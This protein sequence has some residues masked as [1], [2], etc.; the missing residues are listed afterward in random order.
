MLGSPSG[1]KR[2]WLLLAAALLAIACLLGRR[3]LRSGPD[4]AG[5]V[6]RDAEQAQPG[7]RERTLAERDDRRTER[8][9]RLDARRSLG[10][11][12]PAAG[13]RSRTDGEAGRARTGERE[14]RERQGTAGADP[15]PVEAGARRFSS[16]ALVA[17][18]ES[19][20]PDMVSVV[21]DSATWSEASTRADYLN[22][23]E[24]HD[25]AVAD[26]VKAL[27]DEAKA[28]VKR[29]AAVRREIKA[30]RD[31]IAVKEKEAAAARA[32]AEER[33]GELKAAQAE[34]RETL[35]G[36]ESRSQALSD[37]LANI[38]EQIASAGARAARRRPRSADP[39]ADGR[40]HLRK[41]GERPRRRPACDRGGDRSR[42]L[43]RHHPLHL[44]RWPRLLLLTRL[45]LLGRGQL[46]AQRRRL[47]LQPAR[48][49]R[50]R[51]L[52][53]TGSR[54][55]D[56]RLRQRRPRLDDDRRTRLRHG[57]R[58]RP[59]LALLAG[60]LDRRVH[61][62]PPVRLLSSRG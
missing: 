20:T 24:D 61:R 18:Y 36:L 8:G 3:R 55:V 26:R 37:N 60:R 1:H 14:A 17:I 35:D 46:C 62:P 52:G 22:Q 29:M 59:A 16:S 58:A 47:P 28:A 9:D 27:R 12:P 44:G 54:P 48:L 32:E 31:A 34:R 23:I 42:E 51:D 45:R 6:R 19:G 15:G 2:R 53:R 4:P 33:F 10:P 57:R 39:R 5:K 25:D 21:L 40:L 50:A 41:P 43:D 11:A 13:D 49:D 56:N 30:A 7:P 38:S